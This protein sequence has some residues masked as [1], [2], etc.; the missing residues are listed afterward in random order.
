MMPNGPNAALQQY[1]GFFGL[2][3][4]TPNLPNGYNMDRVEAA[5][6]DLARLLWGCP[7]YNVTLNAGN[8]VFAINNA[9][10]GRWGDVNNL[11]TALLTGN[12]GS[13]PPLA[14]NSVS[15]L[16]NFP[17]PG[18]PYFDDDGDLFAGLTDAG[19]FYGSTAVG[20]DPTNYQLPYFIAGHV[21]RP[22]S[23][24]ITGAPTLF[25]QMV[26]ANPGFNSPVTMLPF[27]QPLDFTGAG[28]WTTAAVGGHG[29]RALTFQPNLNLPGMYLFY[30]GYQGSL[31]SS[32]KPSSPIMPYQMAF[33]AN[34][35]VAPYLYTAGMSAPYQGSLMANT[36]T[37]GVVDEG[38]ETVSIGAYAQLSDQI[39]SLDDTAALQLSQTDYAAAVGQSRVRQLVSFN[40]EQ[41]LQAAAIRQ[42]FTTDSFDRRNHGFASA[43]NPSGNPN[44]PNGDRTWEYNTGNNWDGSGQ[45]QF[46]PMVLGKKMD[47]VTPQ[48]IPAIAN[49]QFA[50]TQVVAEPFRMELAALIGA[51]L[52]NNS[53]NGTPSINGVTGWYGSA[54]YEFRTTN[55]SVS[56]WQQQQRLN[57]NRLVTVADPNFGFG[58][59]LQQ[60]QQNPLRFRELTPHPTLA[61]WSSSTSI[62]T[63][64]GA[65][66][67]PLTPTSVLAFPSVSN[68]NTFG[69]SAAGIALQ[70]YWARRDRQQMARDIY[71]MLYMFGGGQDAINY[72]TTPN[73]LPTPGLPL[74]STNFRPLY[75][76]WQLAE[77]AQFAA[78]VVDSLDRDDTIT[79]FEYDK[80][81]HDGWNLD[82]D[83]I[84]QETS[85]PSGSNDRGLV[86]GVEAQQM[87]FNEALVIVSRRVPLAGAP[88]I[89]KDHP[90]T[91]IDDSQVDH[92]FVSLELYN[93]SPYP[94]PVQY[95]NWQ[96][97]ALD[98]TIAAVSSPNLPLTPQQVVS[99]NTVTVPTATAGVALTALTLFDNNTASVS[100]GL[101]YTIGSRTDIGNDNAS[102]TL[103]STFV[104]D[105]NW[106][107]ATG[108]PDPNFAS[109]SLTQMV[110]QYVAGN[111]ATSAFNLDLLKPAGGFGSFRLTD[112]QYNPIAANGVTSAQGA[113]FDMTTGSGSVT[114]GKFNLAAPQYVSTFVLRRRLNLNRPA[115]SITPG[116]ADE[117]DNPFIEVDRITYVNYDPAVVD[118]GTA[119]AVAPFPSAVTSPPPTSL[120]PV[121]AYGG[122]AAGA[123]FN[124]RDPNDPMLGGSANAASYDIRPKLARLVSKQRRQPLDGYESSGGSTTPNPNF[125]P[126]VLPNWPAMGTYPPSTAAVPQFLVNFSFS[127]VAYFQN[128]TLC[129]I[130]GDI[131]WSATPFPAQVTNLVYS[132]N[133]FGQVSQY[134]PPN[135]NG[136][137]GSNSGGAVSDTPFT[138]WQ[139]H[140]D[141]DFASVGELLSVPL[142]GPSIVTQS[143]AP[144]DISTTS[145]IGV[146]SL[147]SEGPLP[148]AMGK[149][150]QPL[151]AQAKI[152]RPQYPVNAG[153]IAAAVQNTQFDNRWYRVLEL[154]EVPTRA[155]MQIENN[156]LSQYPWLFPQALQR[157]PG[158]MNL[159]GLRYGENLFALLDDPAQFSILGYNGAIGSNS[160]N[161]SYTDNFEAGRDWWQQLLY[162]RDGLDVATGRYMP[163]SPAS[164]PFRP[165][166]HF[167]NGTH[168]NFGIPV[169]NGL[170]SIDDTLLR[171]LPGDSTLGAAVLDKRGL[172]EARTQTDLSSQAGNTN[173]IDYYT[174]QRLLSKIAG[175]TTQRSNVFLVWITVGFFEAYQPNSVN[176]AIDPSVIQIGAE[177]TDQTRR[178]GFFVV[179]RSVL[180]DAWVPDLTNPQNGYFDYSKFIQYRKTIQ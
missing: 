164:R 21:L 15:G 24:P 63:T 163:G 68:G 54:P 37:N 114:A 33:A 147:A 111:A 130:S 148:A 139:P 44:N 135:F 45:S 32:G 50:G 110:P 153:G 70:E 113:F 53:F 30:N 149:F 158:K 87:A 2:S 123:F 165:M 124:L 175:N 104:V 136:N 19:Y 125:Y 170:N 73:Q 162:A 137:N 11:L 121:D 90:A 156:L 80:D 143:L 172:F 150:Y 9:I 22:F 81:L 55:V 64:L 134:L 118:P 60:D 14:F 160:Q 20:G 106:T 151:A 155:N 173:T 86:F 42:R 167:D 3:N 76:D 131:P 47:Q 48:L 17:L 168:P 133:T 99:G 65:T 96:I 109:K 16:S 157:A 141:R 120:P 169:D 102:G 51:K 89:Y 140:F 159:N 52:N 103:P 77:M 85:F 119:Q 132:P 115:P 57:I 82:D 122:P 105:P 142:Y 91:A 178:R 101:P 10:A 107:T 127:R 39:F 1:R 71:V 72:A 7:N 66:G 49:N 98:P 5:N 61:E 97:V 78:N 116:N 28:T 27:G 117:S 4:S 67:A 46:P 128:Q 94:V 69:S 23:G 108:N 29:Q 40:F 8:E 62:G 88:G 129:T 79:M 166:S 56:P 43:L 126:T 41:N 75:Q 83:S 12:P 26:I 179:D 18:V 144:K 161:G 177:M 74:S 84:T 171:T 176:P 31:F 95:G 112:Y 58:H 13:A 92:T 180:E 174:R 93:V 34:S 152:F 154:L 59:S 36:N 6:M 38:D 25:P 146:N 138:L 35:A 100:P 145:N